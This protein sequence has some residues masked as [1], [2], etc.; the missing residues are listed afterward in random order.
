MKKRIV[1]SLLM[2]SVLLCACSDDGHSRRS[3]SDKEEKETEAE[4]TVT[5]EETERVTETTVAETELVI[6]ETETV[7]DDSSVLCDAYT[8]VVNEIEEAIYQE[9]LVVLDN[10]MGIEEFYFVQGQEA[11]LNDI[12]VALYDFNND[13]VPELFIIDTLSNNILSMYTIGDDGSAVN[14]LEG[15]TRNSYQLMDNM[16]I[17]NLASS[18]WAYTYVFNWTTAPNGVSLEACDAY[19]ST[20]L[21]LA[22]APDL[23]S[24]TVYWYHAPGATS[25]DDL[26][27]NA[28]YVGT[29]IDDELLFPVGHVVCLE[30]VPIGSFAVG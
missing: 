25:Y 24:G 6:E 18:G 5:E 16:T 17:H 14:M 15:M 21:I 12:G 9:N 29:E 4:T 30:T 28:S 20:D 1:A 11:A 23:G 22:D 27:E 10:H 19:F 7:V 13:S 8:V 26:A 2:T 3:K